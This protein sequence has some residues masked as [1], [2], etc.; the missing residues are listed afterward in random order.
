M[1]KSKYELMTQGN[2]K[3]GSG[4]DI[5]K[6]IAERKKEVQSLLDEGLVKKGSY[7]TLGEVVK[8]Y[9]HATFPDGF[10]PENDKYEVGVIQ[11]IP[12]TAKQSIEEMDERIE[13]GKRLEAFCKQHK[14]NHDDLFSWLMDNYGKKQKPVKEAKNAINPPSEK[15]SKFNS[16][17]RNELIKNKTG[18]SK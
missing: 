1:K 14:T 9:K 3:I 17:F 11:A 15:Q 12:Q 13:N 6:V 8:K 5:D 16:N 2:K 7:I 4:L 10:I 18:Y